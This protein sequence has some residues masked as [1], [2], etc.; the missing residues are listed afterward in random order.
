MVFVVWK[1][2]SNLFL[3][4]FCPTK[5]I[6]PNNGTMSASRESM[7]K[8][9]CCFFVVVDRVST[10]MMCG[11]GRVWSHIQGDARTWGSGGE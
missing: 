10:L 2:D 11:V 4:E 3:R 7:I 9:H 6:H 1:N 8:F 5:I